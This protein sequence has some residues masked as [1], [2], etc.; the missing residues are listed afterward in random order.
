LIHELTKIQ[1][2]NNLTAEMSSNTVNAYDNILAPHGL[3]TKFI[4]ANFNDPADKYNAIKE[5]LKKGQ[6]VNSGMHLDAP[7]FSKGETYE[8]DEK[9]DEKKPTK[10]HRV[11]I[12][13]FDDARKEWIVNDSNRKE[14]LVRYPYGD[15]EL[16]NG[17]SVV[18]EK[19]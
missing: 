4:G 10:G 2:E 12:V 6:I 17:W 19:K 15:F 9:G 18:V 14:D 13:G 16:G 5:A 1:F 8:K 3:T 11:N 7:Q